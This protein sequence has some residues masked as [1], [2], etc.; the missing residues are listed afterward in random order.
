MFLCS[1]GV[2]A[3]T[4]QQARAVCVFAADAA[5]VRQLRPV[6][7]TGVATNSFVLTQFR[8][9]DQ[10]QVVPCNNRTGPVEFVPVDDLRVCTGT[11]KDDCEVA[12]TVA[13]SSAAPTPAAS[14]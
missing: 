7:A 8:F 6:W 14:A 12:A 13:V 4:S 1:T 11:M 5:G 9:M 10:I 2:P 3:G